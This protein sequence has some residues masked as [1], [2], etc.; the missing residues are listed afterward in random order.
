MLIATTAT[1]AQIHPPSK[2]QGF[3]DANCDAQ[4][5][6]NKSETQSVLSVEAHL[7][8]AGI[9]ARQELSFAFLDEI[10]Q[11]LINDRK[12]KKLRTFGQ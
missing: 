11:A 5:R 9:L 10:I 2:P 7:K 6:E 3:A 4:L 8:P 1:L 12:R